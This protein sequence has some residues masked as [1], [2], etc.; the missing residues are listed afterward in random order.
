MYWTLKPKS[1]RE[2]WGGGR[3][4]PTAIKKKSHGTGGIVHINEKVCAPPKSGNLTKTVQ[5]KSGN[6]EAPCKRKTQCR[7]GA[8]TIFPPKRGRKEEPTQGTTRALETKE[9][10]RVVRDKKKD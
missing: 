1:G 9:E 8:E 7:W 6:Q 3:D 4:G 2:V 10:G 5:G